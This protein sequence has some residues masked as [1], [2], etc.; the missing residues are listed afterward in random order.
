M[1]K[2]SNLSNVLDEMI[3]YGQGMIASAEELKRCGD[4]LIKV[5]AEIKEAFSTEEPAKAT[6]PAKK[7]ADL[8]KEETAPEEAP[9]EKTYSFTDVR[10]ALALAEYCKNQ[11]VC[12]Y[13]QLLHPL[14]SA[15]PEIQH[16][17]INQ[18][19]PNNYPLQGPHPLHL[20]F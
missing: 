7:S 9:V 2:M 1:S 13:H 8:P 3:Q 20:H 5:A 19:A 10:G 18:F 4:G 11:T 15:F 6:K 12:E 14:S 16:W 17:R